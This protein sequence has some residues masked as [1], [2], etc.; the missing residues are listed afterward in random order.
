MRQTAKREETTKRRVPANGEERLN[1]IAH[2]SPRT[3]RQ[4]KKKPK[5]ISTSGGQLRR[6]VSA[7]TTSTLGDAECRQ[8][9][10]LVVA[11]HRH[12]R[13]LVLTDER[14]PRPL[15]GALAP[16]P[17]PRPADLSDSDRPTRRTGVVSPTVFELRA[18][19]LRTQSSRSEGI[20]YEDRPCRP[21]CMSDRT[22][23][24]FHTKGSGPISFCSPRPLPPAA[25]PPP[26]PKVVLVIW[27]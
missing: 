14:T 27:T 16:R 25:L 5:K 19:I 13:L 24:R 3:W 7:S 11:G 21:N 6:L 17:C 20:R 4:L 10:R 9:R 8:L 26:S 12:L 23:L 15:A 22:F 2:I 18:P 1:R